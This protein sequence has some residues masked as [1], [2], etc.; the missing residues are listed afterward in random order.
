MRCGSADGT[1]IFPLVSGVLSL[2]IIIRTPAEAVLI[3]VL[4]N[5]LYRFLKTTA[6]QSVNIDFL[7]DSAI[8]TIEAASSRGSKE[9]G[10]I[11]V[12]NPEYLAECIFPVDL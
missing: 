4:G 12:E 6:D 11:L 2:S 1:I 7:G 5:R 9:S 3:I 10:G 8:F